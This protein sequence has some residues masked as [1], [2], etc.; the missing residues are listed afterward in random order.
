MKGHKSLL[1]EWCGPLVGVPALAGGA[2]EDRL[3]PV[4]QPGPSV[5][6]EPGAHNASWRTL[7]LTLL[8]A[9]L[10]GLAARA[11]EDQRAE[12]EDLSGWEFFL[13]VQLPDKPAKYAD[14]V[15]PPAA[16]GRS[17]AANLA[18]LRLIDA[19]GRAVPYALRVRRP[20][21]EQELLPARAFD[22]ISRPDRSASISLDLG[23]KPPEHNQIEVDVPGWGYGRPLR[24]EGSADGKEWGR[25]LD[26]VY[27]VRLEIAGRQVVQRRF[28]YPP[29]RLRYLRV[30]VQPDR[31]LK[32]DKPAIDAVRV[33]H[34][35]AVPGEELLVTGTLQPREPV[36]VGKDPG[37]AWRIDL[38]EEGVPCE[39]L[40]LEIAEE[41]YSRPF[42]LEQLPPDQPPVVVAAGELRHRPGQPPGPLTI[43]LYGEIRTRWLRLT[44]ADYRNP[45]LTLQRVTAAAPAR[46]VVFGPAAGA[47]PF[48]LYTGNPRAQAPNYDFAASL[49][50]R[51]D[52]A[53]TRCELGPPEPNP[54]YRPV[55]KPWTERWRYLVDAVLACAGLLLA[56]VL[57]MLA[58]SAIRRHDALPPGPAA[59]GA[60]EGRRR[61]K[62]L[63]P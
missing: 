51:L 18:D 31:V 60:E 46:Q 28:T 3:K 30:T 48:R 17:Q 62:E 63:E 55:P 32:D 40:I 34:A 49:P 8:A 61:R 5:L 36:R 11:Q 44:V 35:V 4:L 39:K 20:H 2:A 37:S 14:F 38:G 16:F 27:L 43:V 12:P 7:A 42:T 13:P 33:F 50:A 23:E 25:L 53:P 57:T 56:G 22:R 19:Q 9:G 59:P 24:L 6:P 21:D 54:D 52:P 47:G 29:S 1:Q 41:S 58:R 45:P 15:V 10:V 26:D